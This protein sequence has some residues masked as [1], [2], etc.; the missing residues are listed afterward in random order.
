MCKFATADEDEYQLVETSIS[1]FVKKATASTQDGKLRERLAAL[2]VP[3][4]PVSGI[5]LDEREQS[6][7]YEL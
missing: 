6:A 1:N 2:G 7:G 5:H 4:Q 3:Q